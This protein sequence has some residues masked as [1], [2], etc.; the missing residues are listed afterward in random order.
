MMSARRGAP[1]ASLL[2]GRGAR[3]VVRVAALVIL[4]NARIQT[5][6]LQAPSWTANPSRQVI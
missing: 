2:W 6:D 5:D 4:E 3:A 1:F